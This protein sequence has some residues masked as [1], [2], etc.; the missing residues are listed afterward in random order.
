MEFMKRYLWRGA[1]ATAMWMTALGVASAETPNP[2]VRVEELSMSSV[3]SVPQSV[4][5]NL[6]RSQSA[7]MGVSIARTPADATDITEETS[8]V[9]SLVQ[10]ASLEAR[11]SERTVQLVAARLTDFS[12]SPSLPPITTPIL[13]VEQEPERVV[14][15]PI[16]VASRQSGMASW[17]GPGFHGNRSASG[18]VFNQNALTAA[19]R[20]LPFGTEVRVTN[21]NNGQS[22]IVRIND[23]GPFSGGR[24]I[25]L[26]RA[27]AGAI[28]MIGSG[29][30]PVQV[31][32]LR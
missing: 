32:I 1:C 28:G 11:S 6:A 15:G 17:Y 29:V 30:A 24:I 14:E 13:P 31:E 2:G 19:H 27:A 20:T 22:V 12:S 10:D 16:Q 18:E 4:T 9:A 8:R 25:D 3:H 26:S 7:E 23:R 21:L 5:K